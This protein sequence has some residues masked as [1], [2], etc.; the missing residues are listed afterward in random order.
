MLALIAGTVSYLHKPGAYCRTRNAWKCSGWQAD[1][2]RRA[3][4]CYPDRM[5][6]HRFIGW[7]FDPEDLCVAK[8]C[9]FREKDRNFVSAL[10]R[11]GRVDSGVIAARLAT[12]P[13]R[14][15]SSVERAAEWLA[16]SA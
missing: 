3:G 15:R 5:P 1:A 11:A 13:E 9:A 4:A 8:L 14:Y 16:S 12:V 2:S 10:L 7:C 6:D